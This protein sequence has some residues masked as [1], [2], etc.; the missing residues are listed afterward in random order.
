[1]KRVEIKKKLIKKV[2]CC[3]YKPGESPRKDC[4]RCNGTGEIEDSIYYHTVN[5]VCWDGDTIK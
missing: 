2:C 1:M 5:G 3:C 4:P